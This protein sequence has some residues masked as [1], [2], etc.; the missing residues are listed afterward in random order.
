MSSVAE[1]LSFSGFLQVFSFDATPL[2]SAHAPAR[3]TDVG[4]AGGGYL[5]SLVGNEYIFPRVSSAP[6][7][8]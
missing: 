2:P 8:W 7:L 3:H 1:Q 4:V 5:G 6:P